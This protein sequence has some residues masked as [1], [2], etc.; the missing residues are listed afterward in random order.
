M[1]NFSI[2][3]VL[4][5]YIDQIVR[6]LVRDLYGGGVFRR[7]LLTRREG[8]ADPGMI[9]AAAAFSSGRARRQRIRGVRLSTRRRNAP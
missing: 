1:F 9:D 7:M 4:K 2:P 6:V 8:T 3:A 5:A